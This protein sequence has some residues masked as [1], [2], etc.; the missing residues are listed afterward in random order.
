M[1]T[2]DRWITNTDETSGRFV[3]VLRVRA[4]SVLYVAEMQSILG[5]QVARVALA[6]LVFDRT[7]SAAASALSFACTVLP[8]I[9]GGAWLASIGD[10][11]SRRAVMVG[12]D[13]VRAALFALMAIPGL[14]LAV[15]FA[16]LVLAVFI[17]PA[18][19]AS[20]V[21]VLA[22]TLDSARFR[23]A[24]GLRMMTGQLAQ[25][26]GFAIGGAAVALLEPRGALLVDSATYVTSAVL[27]GALLGATGSRRA[28]LANSP[29]EPLA[30]AV[31][32]AP[33]DVSPARW[34]WRQPRVRVLV[35]LGWLAGCFVAP[36]GLAV[37]FAAGHGASATETGL[38]L[39]AIPLGGAFGAVT[40]ARLVPP[41]ARSRLALWMAVLAGIPLI[42]TV[43]APS[44]LAAGVLWGL[45]GLF[46]AYQVEVTTQIV[47]HIPDVR[48][49]GTVGLVA[50]GLI[51]AQGF[52]LIVFGLAA[53]ATSPGTAVA[54]AGGVG[55]VL[56]LVLALALGG[57]SGGSPKV[58]DASYENVT[59]EARHSPPS[60]VDK[61]SVPTMRRAVGVNDGRHASDSGELG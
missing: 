57:L 11:F 23:L 19:T 29:D 9:A 61:S 56:A 45:S 3:D 47:R 51:G 37:P 55:S 15:L 41:N 52:G 21:S 18:F 60:A 34:L 59:I 42:A 16:L 36:E 44:V 50:A 6:V 32:V 53:Q 22:V 10:R 24:T 40:V 8:A 43:A 35:A 39:A 27:V 4:F 1:A 58:L 38:L 26:A 31:G 25:I 54:V 12:C 49:A 30:K 33:D 7:G 13:V 2:P 17:G 46:A 14:P 5:D 20:E 28:D 48:R